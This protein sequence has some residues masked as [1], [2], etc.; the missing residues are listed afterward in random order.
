MINSLIL[1]DFDGVIVDS[2]PECFETAYEAV[3]SLGNKSNCNELLSIKQTSKNKLKSVFIFYRGI[4]GP[5]EHFLS[6]LLLSK[7]LI[8]ENKVYQIDNNELLNIFNNL[9]IKKNLDLINFKKVFFQIRSEN[10]RKFQ[11]FISMNL[12]TNFTQLLISEIGKIWPFYILSSKD[13]KTIKLWLDYYK[14]EVKGI[15][16]NKSLEGF[17]NNKYLL[18]KNYFF[19]LEKNFTGGLFIDDFVENL[20][21]RFIKL[22]IKTYFANWGYGKNNENIESIDTKE[23]IKKIKMIMKEGL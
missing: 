17:N 8:D 11:T 19:D 5:P 12:P 14:V 1:L 23:A 22:G 16:G 7:K 20:D 10:L 21:S 9:N 6:L 2:A 4:V 13:E 3:L 15:I 18:V